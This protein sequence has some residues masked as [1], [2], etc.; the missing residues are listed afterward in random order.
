VN[1]LAQLVFGRV[2]SWAFMDTP[3]RD[4]RD[5]AAGCRGSLF[6]WPRGSLF[7]LPLPL[8]VPANSSPAGGAPTTRLLRPTAGG[9]AGRRRSG[10]AGGLD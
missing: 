1:H 10:G 9:I 7:S 6:N 3:F 5:H 4:P 8:G 2:A